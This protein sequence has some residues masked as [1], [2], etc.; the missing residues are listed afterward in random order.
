[1]VVRSILASLVVLSW[2]LSAS[3]SQKA[4]VFPFEI[5]I[6]ATEEDFYIGEK[7]ASPA[8]EARLKMVH[9]EFLKQLTADG[10]YVAVDL[11]GVATEIAAAQPF[12]NCIECDVDIAKKVGADLA[13]TVTYDKISETHL[14]MILTI[15]DVATGAQVRNLQV[16]VQGNT[17]DT[18]LHGARW[19]LKNRILA[20][21]QKK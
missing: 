17:D 11:S 5:D 4:A 15:R 2:S 7:K 10:R 21:G 6:Q 9:G 18:W 8:E 20:E 14:N 13:F 3:A 1:M 19:L 12:Y 16:V